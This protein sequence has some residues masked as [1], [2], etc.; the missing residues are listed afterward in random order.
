MKASDSVKNYQSSLRMYTNY[1]VREIKKV[2]KEIGPRTSASAEEKKAQ[3]YFAEQLKTCA[4]DVKLEPVKV[5][6]HAFMSWVVID[7]ICMILAVIF[8]LIGLAEVSIALTAIALICL[9]CEFLFYLEFLDK[10]PFYPKKTGYNV[11]GVKKPTGEVKQ[12]IVFCGHSDSVWEWTFTYLGGKVL[13]FAGAGA[14]IGGIFFVLAVSIW[15]VING[16][17]DEGILSILKYVQLVFIPFFI[18]VCFFTNFKRP[19][20]GA[21]DNL[22]GAISSIA[23]LKFLKD[24]DIDFEHTEVIGMSSTSEEAGL[25]GARAFAIAHKEELLAIPT[26]F[27]GVDTFTDY[28]YMAVYKRDM[29]GLVKNDSRVCNLLKKAGQLAGVELPFESVYVGASDAAAVSKVGI[30]AATLA[31]MDPGPP[32][33]YHTRLDTPEIL[34]PKTIEKCLDICIQATFL[35][36]EKGLVE[37]YN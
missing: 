37:D 1:V 4:D 11:Y 32:R 27:V 20:L 22:T 35:F 36:D 21:N 7:G 30:P 3:E 14:A 29:T 6:P 28:E 5:T 15:T 33:Y 19:V 25:R 18:F 17:A 26:A 10:L 16:G 23:V 31:S 8:S 13:L 12:R 34:Q 9:V 2:C 24:N